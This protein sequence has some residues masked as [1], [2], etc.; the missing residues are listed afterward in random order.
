[1]RNG[2]QF[3]K[4]AFLAL[5]SYRLMPKI[6][7]KQEIIGEDAEFFR[8]CFPEDVIEISKNSKGKFYFLGQT[9]AKV[10]N[11]RLDTV[12]RE[13]LRHPQFNNKV[14]L[15]RVSDHFICKIIVISQH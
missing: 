11:E 4:Q 2:L 3:V 10:A 12:S 6:I 14:Q 13:C 15:G 9:V 1:M 8:N 5:C 7:I